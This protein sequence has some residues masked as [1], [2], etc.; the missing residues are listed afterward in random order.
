MKFVPPEVTIDSNDPFN[1]DLFQR[2]RFAQNLESLLKNTEDSLVIFVDAKWGEGKTSF[3]RMWIEELKNSKRS[4]IYFDA[5]SSDYSNDPFLMF[6]S[7]IYAFLN[8]GIIAK[9][10]TLKKKRSQLKSDA[11]IVGKRL[12]GLAAKIGINT[13]TLGA[14]N[15]SDFSELRSIGKEVA[16]GISSISA[17]FIEKQIEEYT[18]EKESIQSFKDCLCEIGREIRNIQGFP[19]TFLIDELDRCRPEFALQLLE[20]IKHLFEVPNVAFIL[21][22]NKAQLENYITNV[23]GNDIDADI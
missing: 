15:Q 19:L 7:E 3:C 2:K 16:S 20:R 13:L 4:A 8:K 23:Y 6:T 21:F 14:I 12:V 1:G 11:A 17:N 5:Y 9:H 18:K 10:H 22:I